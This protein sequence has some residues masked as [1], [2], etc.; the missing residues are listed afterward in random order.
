MPS[1]GE[2]GRHDLMKVI[3]FGDSLIAIQVEFR[4]LFLT[5][6]KIP[7]HRFEDFDSRVIYGDFWLF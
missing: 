2:H 3:V 5:G 1:A 4:A 7:L 6:L